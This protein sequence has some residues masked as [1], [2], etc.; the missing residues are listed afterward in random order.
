MAKVALVIWLAYSLA[1]KAERVKTFTVGF[2]P[3]L[4]VAGVFMLLCLKQ[5]DFGSA[6]VLLLLTFTLLF[7]AGREGRLHP[8]RV[9]PRRRVRRRGHPLQRVPLRAVPRLAAHGPAPAGPRLPAVPERHV[10]RLGRA[11]GARPRARPADALPARGAHRLRRRDHRRG[12]R[13]PRRRDALRAR[14]CSS[15]RA[16]CAPRCARPTTSARYL[17]FGLATMFGV[18]ALVNLAVALAHPADQGPDAAVRQLRRIVAPR[19]RGRGRDPAQHLAPASPT[20]AARRRG[21]AEP[22]RRRPRRR[23]PTA[24]PSAAGS[25]GRRREPRRRSLIAGGGTGRSRLPGASPSPRRCRRSPTS[26]SSSSGPRAGVEAR[27]VPARGWRLELLDVEPMKGGGASAGRARRARRGARD[28]ARR[29]GSCA[30]LRPRAV[31]SVGGYAAGPVALAAALLG[32]P[33]AV[34]EPNSVVGPRQPPPRPVRAARVRRLGRGG[35][36]ASRAK[37][38]AR[39]GVPLRAG[40]A[41]AALRAATGR[42]ARA[43]LGG[44]QG[45]AALNERLPEAARRRARARARRSRSSTRPAATAT[46]RFAHAYARAGVA[47]RARR[48]VHRRRRAGHR[49]GRPGRRPRRR[50]RRS[51]RSRPSGARR[52]SFPFPHAADDHQA[53]NAAGARARRRRGLRPAGGGRRRAPRRA[54]SAAS[55][56]DDRARTRMADASRACGRPRRRDATSRAIC[57]TSPASRER[58]AA[59]RRNGAR[60]APASH[61]GALDVPR[62]RPARPL[63]R[64]RRHRHERPRRDPAHARVRRHA[65]RTC[66]PNENTRRLESARRARLRRPRGR[67]RRRAPTSSSTR[68]P[69]TRDNPEIARARA[70]EIPIIPRAEMLAEL[71]RV[72]TRSPSPARTA[73][74][75]R[76]RSSPPSCAPPGSIPRWSSAARSTRSA[77]TRASAR[78]ISSSPRPTRATGRFLKLTPTIAVVTNIDAEHL[79]HYGTHESVKDAFVAVRQPRPLLRARRPLHRPPAACRRS[80]RA[81]SAGTSPTASRARPTTARSNPRFEGL[82]THFDAYPARASRS[83]TFVVHMPGAH[84]VLNALAVI[85][86]A[87]EL[88][89]PLDVTREAIAA[90]HGVQ[91][92]FTVVGQPAIREGRQAAAT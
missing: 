44:S 17:A 38:G 52:S 36:D 57:S 79:D 82:A 75:R 30:R 35:A 5:P 21:A 26:T 45:A 33:V 28:G 81:S 60:A 13:V 56:R 74:R 70:L 71:M 73:R 19:E 15:S 53:R 72:S 87:D 25:R 88:E 16:A 9:H 46:P 67:E 10:V 4:I 89:V 23:A 50:R 64:H 65:A 31:L 77:R 43:R 11:V 22:P 34:L 54:R 12:A 27:V 58:P 76:P 40:F 48:P 62:S 39:F 3:H 83:A 42:A 32:V 41:P 2:L 86:V 49:R 29:S 24:P 90:F 51:P 91:R 78:A 7:V 1:K 8:R 84:N 66:K 37:R 80:S 18:Q 61:G 47:R 63:R 85:A 20:R 92:R 14:T 55:S 68:A 59:R 69:S 6:V